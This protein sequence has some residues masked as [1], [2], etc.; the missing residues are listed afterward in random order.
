MC[1]RD[2]TR[3]TVG[4]CG[5]GEGPSMSE[6]PTDWEGELAAEVAPIWMS[7]QYM[8]G[9][10]LDVEELIRILDNVLSC[11]A[12]ASIPHVSVVPRPPA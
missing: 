5:G 12:T 10:L 11:G 6:F 1:I 3:V 2:S 8:S 7:R 9:A 4:E